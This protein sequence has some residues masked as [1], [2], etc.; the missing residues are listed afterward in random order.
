MQR[1]ETKTRSKS[2]PFNWS[3]LWIVSANSIARC[4]TGVA[5]GMVAPLLRRARSRA[6]S[7]PLR[8]RPNHCFGPHQP[9]VF[10]RRDVAEAQRLLAQRRPV[11]VRRLGDLRGPIVADL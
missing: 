3:S 6:S 5:H 1:I 8:T 10:Y 9:V 11:G 7:E 4:P 2:R